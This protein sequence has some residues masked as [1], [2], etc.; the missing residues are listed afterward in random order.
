MCEEGHT[1]RGQ[2][3]HEK[4]EAWKEGVVLLVLVTTLSDAHKED[5]IPHHQ[6]L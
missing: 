4:R 6:T 3:A 5:G 2:Q 1:C